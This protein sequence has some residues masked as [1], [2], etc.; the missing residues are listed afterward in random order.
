[1]EAIAMQR[2]LVIIEK[3]GECGHLILNRPEEKNRLNEEA[4]AE[5]SQ[6]LM[7]LNADNEIRLIIVKSVTND[8]CI[9]GDTRRILELKDLKEARNF[10]QGL[11][12]MY[13]TFHR[14]DKI[15]IAMV[16]GYCTSGG[17]GVA[18]S[19][20]LIVA[21]EDAKFGS[22]AVNVGLMCLNTSG[23]MLPRLVGPKKA[24]E[25]ALIGEVL[26]SKEMES[27]GVVNLVVPRDKLENATMELAEKILSKNHL[28]IT[29]GKR[30]FYTCADMEYNKGLDHSAEIFASLAI[31][32]EARKRMR[33]FLEKGDHQGYY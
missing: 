2:K 29:L 9:G 4:F 26:S 6:T 3:K 30:N 33:A 10:F 12:K 7:E 14:V 11:V 31:T 15:V 5:I 17:L 23:V 21:S 25:M 24:L 13:K 8:F 20:D 22:L 27:L 28:S 19:C 1:M 32:D 18:L 16:D